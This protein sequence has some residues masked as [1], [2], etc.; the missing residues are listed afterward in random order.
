[1]VYR[2]V[3]RSEKRW[4]YDRCKSEPRGYIFPSLNVMSDNTEDRN[5]TLHSEAVKASAS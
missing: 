4:C 2:F 5:Y 3:K 1:M